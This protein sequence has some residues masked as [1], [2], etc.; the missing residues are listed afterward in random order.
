MALTAENDRRAQTEGSE[1]P[2]R[3]PG[4]KA[5]DKLVGAWKVSGETEG[6]L[7]Y[8]WMDGGFFLIARGDTEQGGR[9]TKHIEIIGYDHEAGAAPAEVLTSRLYTDNGGTLS[10]THEVDDRGVTSWFGA[11]GSPSVFK[12]R[13]IDDNT[14]A[15]AWEWPGGGYKLTMTRI[16]GWSSEAKR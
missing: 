12:A 1:V 11:K 5:L 4:L 2:S 8:E 13:W 7:T 6:Q 16:K 10:Y 14:L 15:G 9:R 3:N